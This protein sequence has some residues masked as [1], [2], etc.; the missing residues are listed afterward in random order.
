MA[1]V[2]DAASKIVFDRFHVTAYLTKAVDLTRRT[3]MRDRS[4]NRTALK[5]AKY[6]YL[7][8]ART[9]DRSE[10]RELA[11]LRNE[12][13]QLEHAWAIKESFTEFWRYRRESSARA[14]FAGWFNRRLSRLQSSCR[15]IPA[16]ADRIRCSRPSPGNRWAALTRGQRF[17]NLTRKSNRLDRS[18]KR[19][20]ARPSETK[21]ASGNECAL[22]FA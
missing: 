12:Y 16:D 4:L 3:M 21:V 11:D 2:R 7:R 9:M 1:S 5:G 8:A 15:E 17:G 20:R 6:S 18:S 22:C 14:V 13:R 19:L 10:R